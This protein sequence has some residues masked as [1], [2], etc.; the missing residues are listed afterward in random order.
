MKSILQFI[1]FLCLVGL[2][3][4][5]GNYF[6]LRN[7][8]TSKNMYL[9]RAAGNTKDTAVFFIGSSR[10]LGGINDTLLSRHIGNKAVLNCGFNSGLFFSNCLLADAII[11]RNGNKI[12]FIEL[13]PL[14]PEFGEHYTVFT[15]V[16]NLDLLS[17][18]VSIAGHDQ[19]FKRSSFYATAF[20]NYIVDRF[21]LDSRLSAYMHAPGNKLTGFHPV[22]GAGYNRT[23]C[24]LTS[25]E[26]KIDSAS[27]IDI[28]QHLNY[29]S[30]LQQLSKKHN[31]KVVFFV[32][33]TYN[34]QQERNLMRALY[35]AL[36]SDLRI[37]YSDDFLKEIAKPDLLADNNH[38]NQ[39]GAN[40]FTTLLIPIVDSVLKSGL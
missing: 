26:L 34:N 2:F 4:A 6:L 15:Q 20:N 3:V 32:P 33:V 8:F 16:T 21:I 18:M 35:H 37:T 5:T 38:L 12:V 9:V 31:A 13:T 23:D 10:V 7:E 27:D 25:N 30:Y 36:P 22:Q 14:L 1:L 24:Y 29:I 40:R 39:N 28:D 17:S 19:I 11:K